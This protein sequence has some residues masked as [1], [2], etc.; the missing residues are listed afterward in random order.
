MSTLNL[1]SYCLEQVCKMMT[2]K[3][4]ESKKKKYK[5]GFFPIVEYIDVYSVKTI[6]K[7]RKFFISH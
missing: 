6:G 2:C 5:K 7:L 4:E 1:K 3:L